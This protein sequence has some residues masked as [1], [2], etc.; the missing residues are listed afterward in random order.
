MNTEA[1]SS[2][3]SMRDHS[4]AKMVAARAN[5]RPMTAEE[6]AL[7]TLDLQAVMPV[8]DEPITHHA[9][10]DTGCTHDH[11]ETANESKHPHLPAP[12]TPAVSVEES[13]EDDQ[14][15][16]MECGKG[17]KMLRRHL[18]E[19]HGLTVS[20][21]RERW[22]LDND[23]PLTAPNYSKRKRSRALQQQLGKYDRSV[24]EG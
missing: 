18:K 4:I 1:N 13:V 6:I 21:Y 24:A 11:A 14:V 22:G 12:T 7:L 23:H 5:S 10:A 3:R 8:D 20:E 19:S 9:G 17:F 2:E 16:C 15:R